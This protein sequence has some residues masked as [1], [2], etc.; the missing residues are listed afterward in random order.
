MNCFNII[1]LKFNK[2]ILYDELWLNN[3]IKL[4]ILSVYN[5]FSH[6]IL[7]LLYFIINVGKRQRGMLAANIKNGIWCFFCTENA[8]TW[9]FIFRV[10]YRVEGAIENVWQAHFHNIQNITPFAKGKFYLDNPIVTY[11]QLTIAKLDY[12]ILF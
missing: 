12:N 8:K 1:I 6:V 7:K 5:Y 4:L 11:N 10:L 9:Q 2:L 3:S